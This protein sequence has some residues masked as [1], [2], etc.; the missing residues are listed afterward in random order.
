MTRKE[1]A[2]LIAKREGKKSQAKM[3]DIEEILKILVHL[4]EAEYAETGSSSIYIRLLK[5]AEA[6]RKKNGG[7]LPLHYVNTTLQKTAK[8]TKKK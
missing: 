7:P 8:D 4:I 5:D 6:I 2:S 1:I 3:G